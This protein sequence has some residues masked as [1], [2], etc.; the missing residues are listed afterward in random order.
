MCGHFCH[1]IRDF[2]RASLRNPYAAKIGV[3]IGCVRRIKVCSIPEIFCTTLP[4]PSARNQNQDT[5]D[6]QTRTYKCYLNNRQG[7]LDFDLVYPTGLVKFVKFKVIR[8]SKSFVSFYLPHFVF[9]LTSLCPSISISL[10]SFHV[11]D[12]L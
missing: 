3:W 6:R 2:I 8:C 12:T 11:T 1:H 4:N 7:C 5:Q 10:I 9:I